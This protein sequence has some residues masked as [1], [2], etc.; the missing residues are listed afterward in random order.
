VLEISAREVVQMV[1]PV[2]KNLIIIYFWWMS[3]EQGVQ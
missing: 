3:R 1:D 2:M